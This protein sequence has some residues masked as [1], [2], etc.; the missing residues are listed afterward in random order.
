VDAPHSLAGAEVLA[1]L[2]VD[3]EHGLASDEVIR[4]RSVLG[5][6]ALSLA[7]IPLVLIQT[8]RILRARQAADSAPAR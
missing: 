4:R 6:N 8:A 1:Y 3:P 2:D 5:R 7:A